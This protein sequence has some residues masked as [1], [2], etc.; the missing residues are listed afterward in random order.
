MALPHQLR[1]RDIRISIA[2]E[3]TK[4]KSLLSRFR[5]KKKKGAMQSVALPFW[6]DAICIN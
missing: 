2:Q 3:P 5:F 6:V 4:Q 1:K